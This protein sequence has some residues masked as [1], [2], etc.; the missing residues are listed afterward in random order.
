M[1]YRNKDVPSA[2][3]LAF[4]ERPFDKSLIWMR[5]NNEP[6]IEPRGIPAVILAGEETCLFNTSLCF[7]LYKKS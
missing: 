4:E 5:K 1:N 3:N 6:I 2:N 7:Q